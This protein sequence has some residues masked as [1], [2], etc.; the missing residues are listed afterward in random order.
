MTAEAWATG[1][2]V[3]ASL[4]VAYQ[5]DNISEHLVAFWDE[6]LMGTKAKVEDI[7]DR[8]LAITNA[9]LEWLDFLA[10]LAG[11]DSHHWNPKWDIQGKRNLLLNTF[12]GVS[13]WENKGT[14]PVLHYVLTQA[15]IKNEVVLDAD[16]I[17]GTSELGDELG[18]QPWE[19][20]IYLPPEYQGQDQ[21]REAIRIDSLFAPCWTKGK[22][23]FDAE[24]FKI[25]NLVGATDEVA[26]TTEVPELIEAE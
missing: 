11:W 15:G 1:K 8:Q 16:F 17:L 14:L 19:Y 3:Y 4:P 18:V 23:I 21:H 6:L 24:R 20:F 25:F 10:P 26:L 12:Q 9:D 7:Y 13:I 2:P 22:I 5:N